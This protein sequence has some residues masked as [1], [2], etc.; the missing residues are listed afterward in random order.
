MIHI[1]LTLNGQM[2]TAFEVPCLPGW[3]MNRLLTKD[4]IPALGTDRF[5]SYAD[6]FALTVEHYRE[7][8]GE[9]ACATVDGP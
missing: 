9:C 6:D 1:K 7:T 3:S 4:V 8:S 5:L 2:V